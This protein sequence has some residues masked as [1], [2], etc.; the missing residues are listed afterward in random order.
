VPVSIRPHE[1]DLGREAMASSLVGQTRARMPPM[2]S[3]LRRTS[4]HLL[5]SAPN[6]IEVT[7][8][9]SIA[10]Y[11]RLLHARFF[12][13]A[14]A[15]PRVAMSLIITLFLYGCIGK[16]Q[17]FRYLGWVR[18][19]RPAYWFYAVAG[20]SLCA[21]LVIQMMKITG[22]SVGVAPPAELLYGVTIGP[23]IEEVIYRGAAFS[24]IYVTACS[25]ESMR[26]LR[27]VLPIALTSLL[28]AW[29]HTRTM[30][31]PWLLIFAMG[32]V[33]AL[34]RWRS[35]STAITALMHAAYNAVIAAAMHLH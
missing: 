34:L 16:G 17:I 1:L 29:S 13:T 7:A 9:L 5:A 22:N 11:A 26:K 2:V 31:L 25:M 15:Q 27:I 35:N 32:V 4:S 3:V 18:P 28:F 10:I 24:V 30:S 19:R 33:Y 8:L 21:L 14:S 6:Y 12:W 23:I 20:G